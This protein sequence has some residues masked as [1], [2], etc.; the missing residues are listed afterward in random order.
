MTDDD[1]ADRS[2]FKRVCTDSHRFSPNIFNAGGAAQSSSSSSSSSSVTSVGAIPGAGAGV[3]AV[4]ALDDLENPEEASA[5]TLLALAEE[6]RKRCELLWGIKNFHD[7]NTK[8]DELRALGVIT[9][10]LARCKHF[11]HK[12]RSQNSADRYI[13]D[14]LQNPITYSRHR[15]I[16][17]RVDLISRLLVQWERR[18][19]A[20]EKN[21]V[22]SIAA[23]IIADVENRDK[24]YV[25][26]SLLSFI[27]TNGFL[28]PAVTNKSRLTSLLHD[29]DFIEQ[30][31]LW[32]VQTIKTKNRMRLPR[33]SS[34]ML[35]ISTI[36][37]FPRLL[38]ACG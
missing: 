19:L 2:P 32:M 23:S 7:F 34:I 36:K 24:E 25:K 17:T 1:S 12:S 31:T 18:T 11:Q 21:I 8:G 28:T 37:K 27:Q 9:S 6:S 22:D 35:N 5:P 3:G 13:I 4:V 20:G 14:G 10:L 29:D 30:A 33:I 26:K 15:I 38:P 16:A